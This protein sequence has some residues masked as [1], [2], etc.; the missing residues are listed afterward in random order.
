VAIA[1]RM[2]MATTAPADKET[3]ATFFF[4]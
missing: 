4:I 3:M 2:E 1:S